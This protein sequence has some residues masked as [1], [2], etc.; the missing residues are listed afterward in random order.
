[1]RTH[2]EQNEWHVLTPAPCE[3]DDRTEVCSACTYW[4]CA[5]PVS[6]FMNGFEWFRPRIEYVP[7][8]E[9]TDEAHD[10]VERLYGRPLVHEDW[11]RLIEMY[12]PPHTVLRYLFE[13]ELIHAT[14]ADP[15]SYLAVYMVYQEY[16]TIDYL[17]TEV[18]VD[19]NLQNAKEG[20]SPLLM[21]LMIT[22]GGLGYERAQQV[23]THAEYLDYLR[24]GLRR[25]HWYLEC[26]ADPLLENREGVSPI[27]IVESLM[28]VPKEMRRELG[29]LL[30]RYA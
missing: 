30:R 14:D 3:T 2:I 18:K 24:S 21:Y 4:L 28:H 20:N 13:R 5:H 27:S 25:V 8:K 16:E 26:G 1:M 29:E 23:F 19:I 9:W 17:L 15:Y 10:A 7:S 12:Q 11:M 6:Y 22:F